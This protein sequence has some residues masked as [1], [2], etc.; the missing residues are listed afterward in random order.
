ME[1]LA[2]EYCLSFNA[3][4][5]IKYYV[6]Y[7]KANGQYVAHLSGNVLTW[8]TN[9]NHLSNQIHQMLNGSD[10]ISQRNGVYIRV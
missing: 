3:H 10:D 4:K 5:S 2:D 7:R 1:R 8:T 9:D 6:S